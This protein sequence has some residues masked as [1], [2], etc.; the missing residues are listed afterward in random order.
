M[1]SVVVALIVAAAVL[2]VARRVWSTMAKAKR[3]RAAAGC[4]DG[5]CK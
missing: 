4:R 3:D 1:Q 2:Y 5:C